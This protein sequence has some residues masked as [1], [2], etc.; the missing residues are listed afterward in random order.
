MFDYVCLCMTFYNFLCLCMTMY[1]YLWLCMTMYDYLWL[2]MT[3]YDYVWLF[4]TLFDYIRQFKLFHLIQIFSHFSYFS[5]NVNFVYLCFPLLK[6]RVYALVLVKLI[7]CVS[8]EESFKVLYSHVGVGSRIV[9]CSVVWVSIILYS[10]VVICSLVK[11]CIVLW[12][13][14]LSCIGI[15]FYYSVLSWIILYPPV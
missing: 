6:W 11:P 5:T 8:P 9:F 12:G 4:M 13:L 1:D 14:L 2:C 10:P 15:I 7:N 3:M